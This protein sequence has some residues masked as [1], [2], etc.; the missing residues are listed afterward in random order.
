MFS[1]CSEDDPKPGRWYHVCF[2]I[3]NRDTEGQELK[4]VVN[5]KVCVDESYRDGIFPPMNLP[6]IFTLGDDF[7]APLAVEASACGKVT[8]FNIWSRAL[9]QWDMVFYTLSC[10]HKIK[11]T[12]IFVSLCTVFS[13]GG[14][15]RQGGSR[16]PW[17]GFY[18]IN[19]GIFRGGS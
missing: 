5:G 15:R 16:V 11:K 10:K 3:K 19:P 18:L 9:S 2:T 12:G 17:E 13:I 6:R 1:L 14:H 8:D 4:V 7:T